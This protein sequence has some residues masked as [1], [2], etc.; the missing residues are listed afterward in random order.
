MT[1]GCSPEAVVPAGLTWP[2]PVAAAQFSWLP[3]LGATSYRM[4]V[5]TAPGVT[6]VGR[7]DLGAATALA[8][9]L[10]G[11]PPALYYV[12]VAALSACGDGRAVERGGGQCSLNSG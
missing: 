8:V 12:R 6:N 1:L 11:V 9:S 4:R 7:L 2:S 10:A 5:G 3:P